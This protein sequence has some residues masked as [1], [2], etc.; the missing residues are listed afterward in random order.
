MK[1][2][3]KEE[4]TGWFLVSGVCGPPS[5]TGRRNA[6]GKTSFVRAVSGLWESP[7]GTIT[8]P[9]PSGSVRPG[10]KEVFVVPTPPNICY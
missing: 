5:G 6:T 3:T 8:V 1:A 7:R 9:C 10:L 2:Q 4:S